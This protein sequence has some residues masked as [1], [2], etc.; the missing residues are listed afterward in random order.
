MT[1]RKQLL[2]SKYFHRRRWTWRLH[3]YFGFWISKISLKLPEL[4]RTMLLMIMLNK[5]C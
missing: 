1:K 2:S 4:R 5:D 3:Y